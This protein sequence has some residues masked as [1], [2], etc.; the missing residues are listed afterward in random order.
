MT[1]T[2]SAAPTSTLPTTST[3]DST[4]PVATPSPPRSEDQVVIPPN[5]ST[6]RKALEPAVGSQLVLTQIRTASHPGVDRVVLEFSGTGSPGWDVSYVDKATSQGSGNTVAV[7]GKSILAI[8]ATGTTYPAPGSPTA[9][10]RVPGD[11]K[12]VVTEVVNDSTFEG[13]TAVFVGLSSGQKPFDVQA[14]QSP[15]RLVVDIVR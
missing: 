7:S 1:S 3:T 14:M 8:R 6:T 12:G 11:G 10:K 5:A 2:S 15:T 9:P 4:Q 13:T